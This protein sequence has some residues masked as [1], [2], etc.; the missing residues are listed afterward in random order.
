MH[1]GVHAGV[2]DPSSGRTT[3]PGT[4]A[5]R[6]ARIAAA[7]AAGQVVASEEAVLGLALGDGDPAGRS[8]S[9]LTSGRHAFLTEDMEVVELGTAR[10]KGF[11]HPVKLYQCATHTLAQRNLPKQKWMRQD[12]RKP[13]DDPRSGELSRASGVSEDLRGEDLAL[14]LGN[15]YKL[16]P[17]R[18]I[19]FGRGGGAEE[20]SAFTSLKDAL[21]KTMGRDTTR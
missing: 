17:P 7:A 13:L 3:Y 5:N 18:R 2:I 11:R 12:A 8:E 20:G 4:I 19:L 15:H 14:A 6:T 9:P 16:Q 10:L 1:S 21:A